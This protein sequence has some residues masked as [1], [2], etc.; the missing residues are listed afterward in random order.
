MLIKIDK[1]DVLWTYFSRFLRI[2]QGLILLPLIL[3]LLPTDQIAIW[4]LFATITAIVS[5]FDLGFSN[6]FSRN[7]TQI[8]SGKN[9]E[10][11]IATEQIESTEK[12]SNEEINIYDLKKLIT[13]MKKYYS[14]ISLILTFLLLTIGSYYLYT[15]SIDV[16]NKFQV[17]LSWLFLVGNTILNFYYNY[18]AIILQSKGLVKET[19]KISVYGILLSML[20]AIV[21]IYIGWGLIAITL[22]GFISTI[23]Y[24]FFLNK[25]YN[26]EIKPILPTKIITFQIAYFK[27]IWRITY[28]VS[29]ASISSIAIYRSG[30]IIISLFL[31]LKEAGSFAFSTNLAFIISEVS[32]MFF[33]SHL[34]QINSMV[35]HENIDG[36]KKIY[37]SSIFMTITSFSIG[38][39]AII[40]FGNQLLGLIG[41]NMMLIPKI[42]F[43]LLFVF[44]LLDQ[45]QNMS[46]F[47]LF[48]SNK[49]NYM[50]P[51]AISAA[52]IV[53]LT[54][55][56]CKINPSYLAVL[57]PQMIIQ[58]C[59]NYWIWP[60]KILKKLDIRFKD[61]KKSIYLFD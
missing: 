49:L 60:Y 36:L 21:G 10:F 39:F 61:I 5:M 22:A 13:I 23:Y 3:K 29:I 41:S 53:L 11:K 2:G 47:I 16:S 40:F 20:F 26:K 19:Q 58:I 31:P 45:I 43:T 17:Y 51:Y 50:W 18:I 24:R 57:L 35:F 52:L 56:F 1:Y 42:P 28:K 12:S 32:F 46:T 30:V 6:V 27:E 8:L 34:P 7:A 44:L 33:Y 54:L 48:S 59:Y 14:Y 38:G 55:L 4:A 37:I 25:L 9:N 15:I